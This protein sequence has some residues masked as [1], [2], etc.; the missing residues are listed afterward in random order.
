M[1]LAYHVNGPALFKTNTGANNARE[2]L[3]ICEDQLSIEFR[4]IRVPVPSDVAG[5]GA[6]AEVQMINAEA[7]VS[8]R[9]TVWDETV[10]TKLKKK[11]LGTNTEGALGTPGTLMAGGSYTF[12][13]IVASADVVYRFYNAY[14]DDS[15][16]VKLGT[17]YSVFDVRF[18]AF[19]Y[20]P[21]TNTTAAGIVLYDNTDADG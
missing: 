1:A 15:I 11:A 19:V 5:P 2:T 10:F 17:K 20:V 21:P 14:L 4:Q 9:L 16:G 12:K 6:A 7:M 8:G 18:K 13:L 3:G